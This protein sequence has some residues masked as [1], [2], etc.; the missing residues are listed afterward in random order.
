MGDNESYTT[1]S[2]IVLRLYDNISI[3]SAILIILHEITT[4]YHSVSGSVSIRPVSHI[5]SLMQSGKNIKE[6]CP[7]FVVNNSLRY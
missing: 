7:H 5:S 4:I 2:Y 6:K 3:Y 1:T